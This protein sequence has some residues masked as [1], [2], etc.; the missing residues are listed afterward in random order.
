VQAVAFFFALQL[1]ATIRLEERSA[2]LRGPIM[3]IVADSVVIAYKSPIVIG[4]RLMRFAKGG[5]GTPTEAARMVTEKLELAAISVTSLSS[6]G[7]WAGVVKKY[8]K[9]VEANARRL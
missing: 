2:T 9:K 6:G 7:S 8:R 5:R 1:F 4:K 3:G